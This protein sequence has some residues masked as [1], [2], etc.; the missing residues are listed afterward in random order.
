MASL[1][2]FFTFVTLMAM[3]CRISAQNPTSMNYPEIETVGIAAQNMTTTAA[4]SSQGTTVLQRTIFTVQVEKDILSLGAENSCSFCKP[5]EDQADTTHY[6]NTKAERIIESHATPFVEPDWV[7]QPI[8]WSLR[9]KIQVFLSV[10]GITGNALVM[11]VLLCRNVV[12]SSADTLVG[13]LATADF[14]TSIFIFPIPEAV[15]VPKTAIGEMY[16]RFVYTSFFLWVSILGSIFT[17]TAAS[18]ERYAAVVHPIRWSRYKKRRH[19]NL[20]L[21]LIWFAATA[22]PF[23]LLLSTGVGKASSSC[24]V[25]HATYAGQIV[26]ALAT[27]IFGFLIPA[28]TMLITQ[29]LAARA[30]YMQSKRFTGTCERGDRSTASLRHLVAMN[31]LLVMLLIVIIIFIVCLG[32]Q[33]TAFF[34]Y[35]LRV[36]DPSFLYG[37][38]DRILTALSLFNSC[39]NPVVYLVLNAQFRAALL[40]FFTC[41]KI[42]DNALFGFQAESTQK[43]HLRNV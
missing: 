20:C 28:S 33:A 10:L 22:L 39:A 35:N 7:W 40:K 21:V 16:C 4:R 8:T 5:G 37:P 2:T 13:N 43:P 25:E 23:E 42:S 26:L 38:I 1:D 34:L 30:L 12:R 9:M 18:L 24:Q 3:S 31:R 15:R 36:L 41:T 14:I 6:D 19:M 11:A 27:F 29:L 17:L 32:P